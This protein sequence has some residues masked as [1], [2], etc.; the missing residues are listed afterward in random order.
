MCNTI[1]RGL[2]GLDKLSFDRRAF[3]R[4][5]AAS[6]LTLAVAPQFFGGQAWAAGSKITAT[7]GAG[8][9][10]MNI[11]LSSVIHSVQ[12]EGVDLE[13]ITTPTFADEITMVGAGKID[14][15]VMPFNDIHRP[16]R[17]RRAGQDRWRRRR[18]RRGPGRSAGAQSA[19]EMEGQK[20]LAHSS[21]IRWRHWPT[22]G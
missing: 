12:E 1:Q 16:G 21:S 20:R 19:R 4:A 9:C 11:I 18:Q 7:H 6:T 3:L 2:R 5:S 17:R 13:L 10:N 15:G 8:M 14:A 22:T